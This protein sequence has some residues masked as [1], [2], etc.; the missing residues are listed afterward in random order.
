MERYASRAYACGAVS[1][2][3]ARTPME[4]YARLW[5]GAL[6]GVR[7][8]WLISQNWDV[9]QALNMHIGNFLV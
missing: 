6:T 7:F 5:S 1:I 9:Y 8:F 4:R 3:I 2:K